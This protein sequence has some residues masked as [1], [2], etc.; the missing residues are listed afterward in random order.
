M[1]KLIADRFAAWQA[2]CDRRFRTLKQNEEELNRIFAETYGLE[3][4]V[5]IEVPNDKVS[6]RL[7]DRGRDI[8]SLISYAVG[9][10]FGRYSLDEDGLILANQGD[11][12]ED[13]LT[14]IPSPTF[15]P[16]EDNIIPVLDEE[17][18]SDDIVGRFR[19]WLKVA[20]SPDTYAENLAYIE[21]ALGMDIRTYFTKK[22]G[23]FYD[24]HC[25]TYSVTGSGKRPIYW[26]F[27]SPNNSFNA[28]IY[29]HRYNETTINDLLTEYVRELRHR[30]DAQVSV[31]MVSQNAREQ[32]QA[33][34]Y[35][36]M[37]DELDAWER[38]VLLPLAQRHVHID[39]DDGVKVNYNRF[40]HALRKVQGLSNW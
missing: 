37:V 27:S 32:S 1:S 13:Y 30:L 31:L 15:M 33:Y 2:D 23:G 8:R 36:A 35:Q 20:Y 6:V 24:D 39:L 3:G 34:K 29:M 11:T 12:M 10:M 40:P 9:C 5:P 18:F 21:D 26:M 22:S 17:W 7:A 28:L 14:R 19:E 4:E 25:Q 16:D 38:D